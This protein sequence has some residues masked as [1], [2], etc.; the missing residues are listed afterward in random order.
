MQN[1]RRSRVDTLINSLPV[2]SMDTLK[3][4]V[5]NL[6]QGTTVHYLDIEKPKP[7]D[8]AGLTALDKEFYTVLEVAQRH[9]VTPKTVYRLIKRGVLKKL[10]GIR[11]VR[12]TVE[13]LKH[14]ETAFLSRQ[15][16]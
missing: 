8:K 16:G 1:F 11:H 7:K 4:G 3:E 5:W 14:Y 2:R 15:K 13:S 6:I 9:K 12:I 10:L